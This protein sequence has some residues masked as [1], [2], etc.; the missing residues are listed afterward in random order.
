[1]STHIPTSF[2]TGQ[3]RLAHAWEAMSDVGDW[4]AFAFAYQ[5][6]LRDYLA[7]SVAIWED[8][9]ANL[10]HS[11]GEFGDAL[12]GACRGCVAAWETPW[13]AQR[14]AAGSHDETARSD[15]AHTH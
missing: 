9:V 3:Q 11:Q 13:L 5:R 6:L 4:N 14:E 1:M 15:A 2:E 12:R 7:A 10:A 8:G